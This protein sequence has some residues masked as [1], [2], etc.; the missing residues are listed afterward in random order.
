M[1]RLVALSIIEIGR[2]GTA[3]KIS[4]SGIEQSKINGRGSIC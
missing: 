2:E 1:S 3:E 4:T